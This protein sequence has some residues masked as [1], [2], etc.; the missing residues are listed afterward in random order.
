MSTIN[1]KNSV[2]EECLR[3]KHERIKIVQTRVWKRKKYKQMTITKKGRQTDR[4]T[5][6]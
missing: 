5:E 2:K 1:Q 4:Q 3:Y 6:R